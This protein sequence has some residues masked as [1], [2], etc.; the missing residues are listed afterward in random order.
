MRL[1]LPL[2]LDPKYNQNPCYAQETG[3]ILT[4]KKVLIN[5]GRTKPL[6][7]SFRSF[8]LRAFTFRLKF[9]FYLFTLAFY[10]YVF[11]KPDDF[12]F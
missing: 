2:S 7:G 8:F 3:K 4:Y 9:R 5:L 1:I 11:S 12:R 6:R 10:N